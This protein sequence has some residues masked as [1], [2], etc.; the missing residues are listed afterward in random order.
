MVKGYVLVTGGNRGIGRAIVLK[1]GSEGYYVI[2]TYLNRLE[3]AS[4]TL[5]MLKNVGGDGFYVKM[6]V[7]DESSVRRCYEVISSEIPYLNVLVNNAGVLSMKSID[8]LSLDEWEYVLRVNLTGTFLVTKYFLPLLRKAPWA[9]IVNVA[10]LAGQT[11]HSITSVAYCAAKAGVIGLTRRLATELAPKIRVNAV[12]PSVIETDM[13]RNILDTPEKRK[14]VAD[15]HPLKDIGRPEDVAEAVFFL[16]TPK[17]RFITGQ[18]LGING[19]RL[20]C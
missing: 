12:A 19:G 1:F 7:S 15:M 14:R 18:V 9:S 11:G 16:A 8:E 5:K 2:F 10:S 3:S 13:T 6:D 17:S 4:E 20:I